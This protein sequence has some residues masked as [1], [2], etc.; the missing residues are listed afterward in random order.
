MAAAAV[1]ESA[2]ALAAILAMDTAAG[3]SIETIPTD[4]QGDGEGVWEGYERKR[5]PFVQSNGNAGA[6]AENESK[7]NE[8]NNF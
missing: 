6:A 4:R 2:P 7:P 1:E 8:K 5:S 3:I